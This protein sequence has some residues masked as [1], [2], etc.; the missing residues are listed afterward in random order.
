MLVSPKEIIIISCKPLQGEIK[1]DVS[2][3]EKKNLSMR[4][5]LACIKCEV[6]L[7]CLRVTCLLKYL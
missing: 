3:K 5:H 1:C 6:L 7:G 4:Y 2:L